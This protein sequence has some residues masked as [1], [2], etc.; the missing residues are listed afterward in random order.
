M[1]PTMLIANRTGELPR[2]KNA[3]ALS[4]ILIFHACLFKAESAVD[5][6]IH[7]R[8]SPFAFLGN[9]QM[10]NVFSPAEQIFSVF[11]SGFL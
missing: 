4:P 1:S 11:K 6:G 7:S 8:G 2:D 5:F 9:S 3:F 10:F